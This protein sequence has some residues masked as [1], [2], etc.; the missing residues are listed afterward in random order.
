MG[1]F[2]AVARPGL[3]VAKE[4]NRMASAGKCGQLN[5]CALCCCCCKHDDDDTGEELKKESQQVDRRERQR[6]RL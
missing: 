4:Q 1:Q 3:R 6:K 2:L 5:R